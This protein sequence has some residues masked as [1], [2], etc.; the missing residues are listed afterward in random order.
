MLVKENKFECV[1][2]SI[3]TEARVPTFITHGE[4]NVQRMLIFVVE[5]LSPFHFKLFNF[6]CNFRDA[7]WLELI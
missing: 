6:F 5:Y 3:Q 4:L 2:V 7:D 1:S